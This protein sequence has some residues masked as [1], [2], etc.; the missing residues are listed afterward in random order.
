MALGMR[1]S[2][3]SE[4]LAHDRR[5]AST[6]RALLRCSAVL[7]TLALGATGVSAAE[8][9]NGENGYHLGDGWIIPGTDASIGGYATGSYDRSDDEPSRAAFDNLSFFLWWD[10]GERWKFFS[11]LEY[12]N[13]LLTRDVRDGDKGYLSLERL[14]VDYAL[15]DTINIR[16]G[17]FLTPIGRWNLIHATPLVWTTSRPLV[18]SIAFPTNMTGVM[19]TQALP[20]LW[21]GVEYSIYGASGDELRPNPAIDTFSQAFGGHVTAH[22]GVDFQ[23][24]FSYAEFEQEKSRPERK[25]LTGLDLLWTHNRFELSSEVVY[26]YSDIGSAWDERGAYLQFVAPLSQK[27]FGVIRYEAIRVANEAYTTQLRVVGLNYRIEPALVL[28]AEWVS[29]SHNTNVE[30]PVGFLSSISVLF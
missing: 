20:D 10:G 18:T 14:Y 12:D 23:I 6:F 30:A 21:Q 26:R 2:P 28:K 22:V 7:A 27:L 8:S 15:T 29:G 1:R 19:L 17:K 5:M 16:G 11:E 25:Q 13:L 4:S 9:A 3:E 24:G